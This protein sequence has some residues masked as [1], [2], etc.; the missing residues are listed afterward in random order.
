MEKR[1]DRETVLQNVS[2][3]DVISQHIELEPK[4][5]HYVAC[6]PFHDEKTPSFT[7][8]PSKGIY[9]C[10]GCGKTGDAISFLMEYKGISYPDACKELGHQNEVEAKPRRTAKTSSDWQPV[11][12]IPAGVPT[13]N[14]T[15]AKGTASLVWTYT[16]QTG[17]PIGYICRFDLPNGK[18]EVLPLTWCTNGSKADWKWQGFA[19]PRPIYNLHNVVASSLPVIIVEGEK[20]AS[21]AGNL[22]PGCV[23]TCWPGGTS[24]VKHVDFSP[25][26]GRSVYLWPDNDEPGKKAMAQVKDALLQLG[27]QVRWVNPPTDAP[28]GWDIA[29][30]PSWRREDAARYLIDNAVEVVAA[31]APAPSSILPI[32]GFVPDDSEAQPIEDS[33]LS[34][35]FL[36]WDKSET[37]KASYHFYSYEKKTILSF[38][39][40]S[41]NT[42]QLLELAPLEFWTAQFPKS[43]GVDLQAAQDWI[44]R[45]SNAMGPFQPSIRGRGAWI[46]RGRTVVHMGRHLVVDGN[47]VELDHMDSRHIY[48]NAPDLG[49]KLSKPASL[50]QCRTLMQMVTTLN[51][52]RPVNAKLLAGWC[53]VAPVCGALPWRPHIWLTGGAGS[54][55][56][57]VLKHI[58]RPILGDNALAAQGDSTEAG[59]RQTLG[60]DAIPI[61]FDEAEQEDEKAAGRIQNVLSLMR[62]ASADDGGMLYKGSATGNAKTFKIR[63]C[64]AYASIVPQLR[65]QADRTRVSILGMI[66]KKDREQFRQLQNLRNQL[67]TDDFVSG[68]VTRTIEQLPIL[69]ENIKVFSSVCAHHLENQRA[70]D[71]VG[72]LMAGAW[73]CE[74]ELVATP[75][76]A[77]MYVQQ[78]DYSDE[79]ALEQTRDEVSLLNHILQ[80][81]VKVPA[82]GGIR[83]VSV[84]EMIMAVYNSEPAFIVPDDPMPD[85]YQQTLLRYGIK[86][87]RGYGIHVFYISN[88]HNQVKDW[89][90]RTSWLNNHNKV[91]QRLDDARPTG[92]MRFGAGSTTR[93]VEIPIRYVIGEK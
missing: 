14:F 79:Q 32:D 20:A 39:A 49:L 86:V 36:G 29:D 25:L 4:G 84:G 12:P 16:D 6:C 24:G 38:S 83:E 82:V 37:G 59:L 62:T 28:K 15:T 10:F 33:K 91:L 89:L 78:F 45:S 54:G 71:Q 72:T 2:I 69:L 61:V 43:S 13:P 81:I 1:I 56:S 47:Q 30:S 68:F 8:T 34:F 53:V 75:D 40:A 85:L 42:P 44:F 11:H 76:Q 93:A 9:S 52:E 7:V 92:P 88:T 67:M 63:S 55:K 35:R 41:L 3:Y 57:W 73:F 18:K 50:E 87:E 21:A 17:Q 27:C 58:I 31:D 90:K 19:T 51:W 77:M 70:G 22:L 5:P 26:A 80:Q 66:T 64:F 60:H 48:E 74:S 23:P 65:L 46:D